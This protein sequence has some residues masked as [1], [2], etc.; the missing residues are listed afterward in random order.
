M[1]HHFAAPS[2]ILD[3]TYVAPA[4]N[5][6]MK[7]ALP[8]PDNIVRKVPVE[9]RTRTI[10]ELVLLKKL[11]MKTGIKSSRSVR[12]RISVRAIPTV[13]EVENMCTFG[14]F[15]IGSR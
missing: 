5:I 2:E 11:H 10:R 8:S 9:N 1:F 7:L 12:I 4:M 6:S 3:V 13:S 14:F 15:D